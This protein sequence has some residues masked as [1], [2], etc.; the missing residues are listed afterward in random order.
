MIQIFLICSLGI[1][2]LPE[3]VNSVN[4]DAV[5]QQMKVD[6]KY[7]LY[8]KESGGSW[9]INW[10]TSKQENGIFKVIKNGEVL[11]EGETQ[12]STIHKAFVSEI[13]GPFL[14]E[15]GGRISGTS[16]IIIDS[17]FE[18]HPSVVKNVDSV[19][20]LGDVH[21][22]FEVVRQ[23]LQNSGIVDGNLHWTGNG[24]HLV[25]DG[26]VMDRGDDVIRVLWF[27]YELEKE[28]KIAGGAV[29]FVLG[30]HEI[31][32]MSNDLRYV[33][34]KEKQR[35]SMYQVAYR[36]FVDP[37]E[38][39]LGRWIASKPSIFKIDNI[40]FSHGGVITNYGDFSAKTFND[41]VAMFMQEPVFTHLMDEEIDS[42]VLSKDRWLYLPSMI[43]TIPIGFAVM[44]GQ[45][46]LALTWI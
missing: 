4:D 36:D 7:G 5:S 11:K 19:Y 29:H 39:I 17:N 22:E 18:P 1:R 46:R 23:I 32:V 21:G 28:A 34:R 44:H 38:T 40:L 25:F 13:D 20:V 3:I 15:F 43:L 37:H 24:A 41:S 42:T 26:D 16:Q 14:L 35:A 12:N 10:L 45:T 9:E 31:M 8:I 33:S 6:G 30:N 2:L 27:I